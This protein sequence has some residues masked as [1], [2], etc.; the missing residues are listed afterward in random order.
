[1]RYAAQELAEVQG[2]VKE[3]TEG[4]ITSVRSRKMCAWVQARVGPQALA[5]MTQE[6]GKISVDKSVRAN[7]LAL[8]DESP[9]EVPPDVAD[10]L[11]CASD[12]WSSSV[13]KFQR[14]AD[15]ADV[16]DHRVRGAFVF[17]GG[18]A[19]GRYASFGIQFQNLSRK[20][21]KD[22]EAVRQVMLR[23]GK[24]DEVSNTLKSMIRP[25]LIPAPGEVFVVS[26]YSQIEAR[27]TP[28]LVDAEDVLGVFRRGEDIYIKAAQGMFHTVEVTSNQRQVG[29]AATLSCSFGGGH[30]AFAAMGKVYNVVLPENEAKKTVD[31]WRKANPWAVKM[32]RDVENTAAG[33]MRNKGYEFQALKATYLYDGQHLWY[34]LPS[35]R[36]LCYPYAR[37][38]ED[39]GMSYAKSAWKPKAD[40]KH[41]PRAKLYSSVLVENLVQAVANDLLRGA[42]RKSP[43]CVAHC[44]DEIILSVP[45][46][47]A[48]AKLQELESIMCALP[49]WA[50]GLPLAVES[51]IMQRYGK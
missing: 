19:T 17:A 26:D 22:P 1:V 3:I 48:Q 31:A 50:T 4:A 5:L 27:V 8:A 28:W 46:D 21:A 49:E 25:A 15:L 32:W 44:H 30:K 43:E 7:L 38:D 10:V 24:L 51:K 9:A 2:L 11:Q 13:A 33:A 23:G 6:D 36:V 39:G 16:E 41:W 37:F 47:L 14:M 42:L 40:A 20:V 35:G 18:S 34:M 29:K 12:I 45:V